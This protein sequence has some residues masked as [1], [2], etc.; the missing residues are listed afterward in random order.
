M[1]ISRV[2]QDAPLGG[3]SAETFTSGFVEHEFEFTRADFERVRTLIHAR[4]GIALSNAKYQ[5]AYGRLARR[6]RIL[7]ITTFRD[8]LIAWRVVRSTSGKS[9]D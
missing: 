2:E 7:G 3:G 4:A 1:P 9:S 6:L 8:Y 5:L